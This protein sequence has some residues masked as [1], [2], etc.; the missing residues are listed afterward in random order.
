MF[1][2]DPHDLFNETIMLEIF[3]DSLAS[4]SMGRICIFDCRNQLP[5]DVIDRVTLAARGFANLN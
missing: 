4:C 2:T 1:K 5:L 3:D